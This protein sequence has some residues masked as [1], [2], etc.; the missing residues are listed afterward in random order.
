MSQSIEKIVV[1]NA[2]GTGKIHLILECPG[3]AVA[4]IDLLLVPIVIEGFVGQP[5]R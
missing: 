4:L 3:T 2:V 5:E 1:A